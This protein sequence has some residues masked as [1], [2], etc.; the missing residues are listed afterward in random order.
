MNKT[1]SNLIAGLKVI[2]LKIYHDNRG[3]FVERFN[4]KIFEELGLPID[5][6]QDNFSY[7]D[8]YKNL[9]SSA[10]ERL[11]NA[12]KIKD[13]VLCLPFYGDLPIEETDRICN[14]IKALKAN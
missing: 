2:E 7:Y 14:I 8:I 4:K 10:K 1:S 13:E 12:N 11:P 3:F 9:E 5:Y 6:Y